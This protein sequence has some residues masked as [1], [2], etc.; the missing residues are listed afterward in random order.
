MISTKGYKR[1]IDNKMRNFGDTDFLKRVIRVNKKKS[2]KLGGRG[3]VL[4]TIYHEEMHA[5][6]PK[7]KEKSV[8]VRTV[9]EIKKLTPSQKRKYYQKYP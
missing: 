6:H 4:D 5:K 8:R 2:K 3:E 7:M 9:R 1:V